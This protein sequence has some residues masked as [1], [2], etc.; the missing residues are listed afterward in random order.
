MEN[1]LTC[2]QPPISLAQSKIKVGINGPGKPNVTR[3]TITWTW[4]FY[5]PWSFNGAYRVSGSVHIFQCSNPSLIKLKGQSFLYI[6]A[7]TC[8]FDTPWLF[9]GT[10]LSIS[11]PFSALSFLPIPR[12]KI[13]EKSKEVDFRERERDG[14]AGCAI[15]RRDATQLSLRHLRHRWCLRWRAGTRLFSRSLSLGFH[16]WSADVRIVLW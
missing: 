10:H 3:Y 12:S 7:W 11:P 5:T 8:S 6:F 2:H 9:S 14:A 4:S 16:L 15:S 1:V 13:E